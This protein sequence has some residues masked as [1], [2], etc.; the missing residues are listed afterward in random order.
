[1]PGRVV[2]VPVAMPLVQIAATAE[3]QT[4]NT[5][6]MVRAFAPKGSRVVEE[7]GLDPG[8]TVY[9]RLPE[10]TLQV[11]TSSST[12][13]EGA[14]ASFV[15][16]DETEHWRPSNGGP[17]LASTLADNL[18]KSGSRMLETCN[19]WVPG[20]DTVAEDSW[21][22]WLAQ[23]EGRTR[24]ETRKRCQ[25]LGGRGLAALAGLRYS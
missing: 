18:A 11:I 2:G 22:G 14:E 25:R 7:H 16:A 8:K 3:S 20:L 6:R 10:G 24:G 15:V 1:M 5:M 13:A 17:D 9:Y 12:A 19:A 21:D 4:A 23:E